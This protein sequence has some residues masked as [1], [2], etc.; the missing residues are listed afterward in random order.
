M[1]LSQICWKIVD[2][3]LAVL[4]DGSNT[5][6]PV[7]LDLD[8]GFIKISYENWGGDGSLF[9]DPEFGYALGTTFPPEECAAWGLFAFLCYIIN[10]ILGL[11]GLA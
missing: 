7:T 3:A 1:I 2:E 10:F 9:H 5:T 11:F 4:E 8:G 6:V